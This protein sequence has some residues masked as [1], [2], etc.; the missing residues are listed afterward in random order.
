MAAQETATKSAKQSSESKTDVIDN[1]RS[2]GTEQD[3]EDDDYYSSEEESEDE[4]PPPKAMQRRGGGQQQQMQQRQQRQQQMQQQQQQQMQQQQQQQDDGNKSFGL[5]LDLNL[6]IEI[7]LKARIHGD[8]TLIPKIPQTTTVQPPVIS[9]RILVQSTL[10]Q[11][12]ALS[13][14][15]PSPNGTG[16]DWTGLD[17][18]LLSL[19]TLQQ[20]GHAGLDQRLASPRSRPPPQ[21]R[22]LRRLMVAMPDLN[23]VPASP[24]A[25]AT[26]RRRSS[27]QM[28]PPPVPASPSL[29]ILPSNQNAVTQGSSSSSAAV[30]SPQATASQPVQP[31]PPQGDAAV[32]PGPG[33]LRH[34][35]P[36]TATELHMQLEKEQEAVVNRLTRE[37]SLLRAAHNASVVSNTSSTSGATSTHEPIADSSL[38]T[39]AGFSIPTTRRHHRTSSS[40][41][42]NPGHQLASSYEARGHTSRS[43]PAPLSRQD[44]TASRRSQTGS[45]APP[46]SF[47]PSSYF[48]Q[49]RIPPSSVQPSSVGATP[50]SAVEQMSPGLMPA[51]QRYEE[52]A[53]YRN[54][55]EVAKKENEALKR[56]IRELE[57]LVRDRRASDASRARSESVSTTASASIVPTMGSSIAGPRESS[58]STPRQERERVLT[59]RSTTSV[60]G[61]V[62]VGVPEEEVK[63]GESAA[64]AGLGDKPQ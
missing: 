24:H 1:K 2:A 59:H 39:G 49:Q 16:L 35:R 57:R 60:A 54:E 47:D 15:A 28:P 38:L 29:N 5:R 43:Q 27:T 48:Q 53:F 41:S 56:R 10:Y 36:L 50:G 64:S 32:G 31:Q 17:P 14:A 33:P 8:L 37:L 61:S 18:K 19:P 25:L 51:T 30:P 7:Q 4:Q 45:P 13:V 42:Q 52:T 63:V 40:A 26:P 6:E 21:R 44:S 22:R 58:T 3:E 12:V 20:K 55:L 46:S 23:S 11:R 9:S 34:P 62:G